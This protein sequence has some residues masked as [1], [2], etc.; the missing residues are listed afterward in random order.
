MQEFFS[1]MRIQKK[2]ENTTTKQAW[3]EWQKDPL[4]FEEFCF[5]CWIF[6]LLLWANLDV[7]FEFTCWIYNLN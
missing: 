7:E 4:F 1:L 6:I 5:C 3:L 2:E